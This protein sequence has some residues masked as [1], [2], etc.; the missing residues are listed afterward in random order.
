MNGLVCV[1]T[2]VNGDKLLVTPCLEWC[3]CSDQ[4][5]GSDHT[6]VW[7]LC[8]QRRVP[9]LAASLQL[10]Q[11]LHGW[12]SESRTT[13]RL[14]KLLHVKSVREVGQLRGWYPH[15]GSSLEVITEIFHKPVSSSDLLTRHPYCPAYNLPWAIHSSPF[16]E[17]MSEIITL[18]TDSVENQ[19]MFLLIF[20][21]SFNREDKPAKVTC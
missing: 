9:F 3:L 18:K 20:T 4:S 1:I 7:K 12:L 11:Q 13:D 5:Q 17:H 16:T 2:H 6:A 14:N 8:K 21:L 19:R 10:T 15:L